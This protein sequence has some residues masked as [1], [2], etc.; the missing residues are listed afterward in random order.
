MI[1]PN[2]PLLPKHLPFDTL[3]TSQIDRCSA[4]PSLL[5]SIS[6]PLLPLFLRD[7]LFLVDIDRNATGRAEL[8]LVE[9]PAETVGGE[10]GGRIMD[11]EGGCWR[12]G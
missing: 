6:L 10:G 5:T 4:S 7:M 2:Q 11:G 8:M 3:K 12:V 9:V 1:P